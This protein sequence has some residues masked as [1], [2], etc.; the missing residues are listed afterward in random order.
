MRLVYIQ[1]VCVKKV[2]T[3]LFNIHFIKRIIDHIK[4]CITYKTIIKFVKYLVVIQEK[5]KILIYAWEES[6]FKFNYKK[7]NLKMWIGIGNYVQV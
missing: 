3:N 7:S 5:P 2:S 1:Y 4:L 6:A